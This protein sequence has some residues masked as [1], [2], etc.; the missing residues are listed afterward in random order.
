MPPSARTRYMSNSG[1]QA[2]QG[3]AE[4]PPAR[5]QRRRRRFT[6]GRPRVGPVRPGRFFKLRRKID[7]IRRDMKPV[8]LGESDWLLYRR[9]F[10]PY[11]RGT[12][13]CAAY[14]RG[15]IACKK[16]FPSPDWS[17]L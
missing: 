15:F 12:Y 2:A 1:Q 16:M 7:W 5:A 6:V 9:R 4:I 11:R 10:N 8:H 17:P 14:E 13:K 3:R